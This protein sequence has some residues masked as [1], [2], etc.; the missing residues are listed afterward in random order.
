[1]KKLDWATRVKIS[2]DRKDNIKKIYLINEE[3]MQIFY[4]SEEWSL[5]KKW[6]YEKYIN[7]CFDCGKTERLSVDHVRPISC[8]PKLSLNVKNLQILCL[9]CNK[10]KSFIMRYNKKTFD[11]NKFIKNK[12]L[13]PIV[14]EKG[15][16]LKF[17]KKIPL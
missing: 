11:I 12:D 6:V 1:M 9:D 10:K 13:E 16:Y 3:V 5:C 15:T 2:K 7:V 4:F 14:F 17:F 8:H